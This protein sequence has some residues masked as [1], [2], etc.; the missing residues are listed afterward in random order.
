MKKRSLLVGLIMSIGLSSVVFSGTVK[1]IEQ[2]SK[3]SLMRELDARQITEKNKQK[4]VTGSCTGK[5]VMKKRKVERFE[6]WKKKHQAEVAQ[7][8]ED[9][10]Y[11]YLG[12]SPRWPGYAS[13][14]SKDYLLTFD[15]SYLYATDGYDAQGVNRDIARLSF[16]QNPIKVQDI[17]LASKLAGTGKFTVNSNEDYLVRLKDRE[18]IILGETNSSV[19]TFRAAHNI[20]GKKLAVGI[21]VPVIFRRNFLRVSLDQSASDLF[22]NG[23]HSTLGAAFTERYGADTQLFVQDILKAK[24]INE[25][26]GSAFGLGDVQPYLQVPIDFSCCEKGVAGVMFTIPTAKGTTK[27]KLWAP[28]LG[29]GYYDT[30]LFFGMNTT[31]SKLI[32]PHF[33][34]QASFALPVNKGFRLPKRIT[35]TIEKDANAAG[36]PFGS[37][38]KAVTKTPIDDFD[39][40]VNGFGDSSSTTRFR[41]GDQLMLRVG[42]V[43]ERMILRQDFLQ[44]YYDIKFKFEDHVAGLDEKIYNLNSVRANTDQTGHLAGIAYQIKPDE[45][46]SIRWNAEYMFAGRNVAKSLELIFTVDFTF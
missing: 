18:L 2:K 37:R 35:K 31:Y 19:T 7:D 1:E 36:I 33:Y 25:L 11:G 20:W 14:V 45:N 40:T 44:A 12:V 22:G 4:V 42:N 5:C 21:R 46:V 10:K 8:Y 13:K 39:T 16:S 28:S 26:G 24:G 32:N 23:A 6:G 27:G 34:A 3:L 30:T 29:S 38:I 9:G 41:R 15:T 43:M 17:L